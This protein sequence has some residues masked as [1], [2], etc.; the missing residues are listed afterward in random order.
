MMPKNNMKNT[1][2]CVNIRGYSPDSSWG[3]TQPTSN[4][5]LNERKGCLLLPE[6][7]AR[8][9]ISAKV[10]PEGPQGDRGGT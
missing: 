5:P 9:A 6:A 8:E 10:I 1:E 4:V 2:I 3:E 7:G